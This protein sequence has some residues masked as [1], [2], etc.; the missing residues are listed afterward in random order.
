MSRM[1]QILYQGLKSLYSSQNSYWRETLQ[2]SRMWQ[3]LY[4]G[5][6]SSD[7]SQNPY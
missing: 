3:V 2:L 6:R 7:S 5:L 4:S 1:W